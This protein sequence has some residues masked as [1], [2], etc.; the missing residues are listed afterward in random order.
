MGILEAR[1]AAERVWDMWEAQL[2]VGDDDGLGRLLQERQPAFACR[3][4]F[5]IKIVRG[6]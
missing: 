5:Q 2:R 3:C 4:G 1:E 6:N